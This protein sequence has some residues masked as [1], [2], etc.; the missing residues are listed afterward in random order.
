MKQ[1]HVHQWGD[2]RQQL[3]YTPDGRLHAELRTCGECN[4]CDSRNIE[5]DERPAVLQP[6]IGVFGGI[7]DGAGRVL[8]KTIETGRFV[9]EIDLPGGGIDAQRASQA[10]DERVLFE[11][12]SRHFEDEIGLDV[13]F[14]A[15]G[16]ILMPAVTKGGSDWAFPV[17][18]GNT[19]RQPRKGNVR[20]LSP[21]NVRELAQMPEGHRILSGWGKR[22]HRL[23]L[24]L[25]CESPNREY[26]IQA[27]QMLDAVERELGLW[28]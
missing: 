23:F 17:V 18:L 5:R 1:L 14:A 16:K 24:R 2:W 9:G 27:F 21:V 19:D 25:L 4:V 22:M 20:F 8:G 15:A 12:L 28:A 13:A 10:L 26:Q 3:W 6:T 7:Y 11:E